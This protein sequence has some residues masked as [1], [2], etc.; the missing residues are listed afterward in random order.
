MCGILC[1]IALPIHGEK[2]SI[3]FISQTITNLPI[4]RTFISVRRFRN[5]NKSKP[6]NRSWATLPFKSHILC[7]VT[8]ILKLIMYPSCFIFQTYFKRNGKNT[9]CDSNHMHSSLIINFTINDTVMS[10]EIELDWID[11][12]VIIAT[13]LK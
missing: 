6:I 12:G 10:L 1:L 3:K 13:A 8:R 9:W 7:N 5:L 4:L 11:T 2:K